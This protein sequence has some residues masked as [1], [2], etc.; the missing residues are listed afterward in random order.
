M[1]LAVCLGVFTALPGLWLALTLATN[2]VPNGGWIAA[3]LAVAAW[4]LLAWRALTHSATLTPDTLVIRNILATRQVPLADITEV[5]FR[6][7]RL[8]VICTH[9]AAAS[10][11]LTVSAVSLRSS[12]WSGLRSDADAIADAITGAAALP[13]LPS[14]REIISRNWAWIMLLAAAV[15]F[16]LG[17]YYGPLQTGNAS[18]SFAL[19]MLCT[20]LYVCGAGML[21]F[22]FRIIRDHQRKRPRQAAAD[23]EN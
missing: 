13:P 4:G 16:G 20:M 22:A 11:R 8:T 1:A 23:E 2:Q 19:R 17:L 9:A 14:R 15:C 6:R 7:G 5:G 12:R 3:A 21:S 18:L 10:E